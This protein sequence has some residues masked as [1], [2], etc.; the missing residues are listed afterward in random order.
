MTHYTHI[1]K[2][3]LK[4]YDKFGEFKKVTVEPIKKVQ[5]SNAFDISFVRGAVGLF[6]FM[7]SRMMF[8]STYEKPGIKRH[9]QIAQEFVYIPAH[10]IGPAI[11]RCESQ[12]YNIIR[13]LE[14]IFDIKVERAHEKHGANTF[15]L[16]HRVNEFLHIFTEE[17]LQA[18]IQKYNIDALDVYALRQIYNYRVIK[19]TDKNMSLEEQ[20]EFADFIASQKHKNF[21]HYC[22]RNNESP[23]KRAEFVE[24][25]QE[26][27]SDTQLNQLKKIKSMLAS[28]ITKLANHYHWALVK[29]QQFISS[30]ITFKTKPNKQKQETP[31]LANSESNKKE[32]A[33]HKAATRV[34]QRKPEPT[35]IAEILAAWFNVTRGQENIS[36]NENITN[37]TYNAICNQVKLHGKETIISTINKVTG[38]HAVSSGSRKMS[39]NYFMTSQSIQIILDSN[40]HDDVNPGWLDGWLARLDGTE[41]NHTPLKIAHNLSS[42]Q[43]VMNWFNNKENA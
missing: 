19:P 38:L 8:W 18:F 2:A 21:L 27:L 11:N 34:A 42:K 28:G 29:L 32:T 25:H 6:N 3:P 33:Q 4:Y 13:S 15:T 26:L 23:V 41:I 20:K 10:Q 35:E 40:I 1:E 36:Q 30:K 17:K 5:I 22:S 43:D 24:D 31:S 9:H 39:L 37:A 12:S 7:I 16:S 14:R